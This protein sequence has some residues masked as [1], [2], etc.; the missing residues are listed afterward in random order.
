MTNKI[1][2]G[3]LV[4]MTA[5]EETAYLADKAA[6]EAAEASDLASN[7]YKVQRLMAYP[8]LGDQLDMIWHAINSGLPL[9]LTSDFYLA[10]K[11]VKDT[12]PKPE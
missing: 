4:A 7:G 6:A 11:A 9:D 3:V 12:Y 1:V 2:N 5:E 8:K 10:L